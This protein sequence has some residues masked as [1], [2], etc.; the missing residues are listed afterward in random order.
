MPDIVEVDAYATVIA[1]L[2]EK[3]E[4]MRSTVEQLKSLRG[5]GASNSA[6]STQGVPS[7]GHDSFFNMSVAEGAKKF[8]A[9]TKKT[10]TASEITDA[11][12]KGGW[13]TTSKNAV[14]TLRVT[15]GRDADFAKVNGQFGLSEWYPGRRAVKSKKEGVSLNPKTLENEPEEF[16]EDAAYEADREARSLA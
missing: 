14:E 12:L 10:A 3:I 15:L 7:F 5:L 11:L 8:L 6:V 9:L 13:K 16:D 2:E 4:K 1:D